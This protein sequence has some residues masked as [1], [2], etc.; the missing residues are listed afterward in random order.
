M[1]G[2]VEP[3]V[4]IYRV[5]SGWTVF[6]APVIGSPIDAPEEATIFI[7]GTAINK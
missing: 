4:Y 5:V 1:P 3:A 7:F 2:D 6:S